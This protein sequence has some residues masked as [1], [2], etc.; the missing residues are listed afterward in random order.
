MEVFFLYMPEFFWFFVGK[1]KVFFFQKTLGI[2]WD[3]PTVNYN[4]DVIYI[5]RNLR[6]NTFHILQNGVIIL[7]FVWS[8][9]RMVDFTHGPMTNVITL[10]SL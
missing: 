4:I 7:T 10:I 1:F 3:A 6:L 5:Q 9:T 2:K 8:L